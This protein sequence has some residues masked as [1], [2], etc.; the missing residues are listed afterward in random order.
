MSI[1]SNIIQ[2][3]QEQNKCWIRLA[4]FYDIELLRKWKNK[5]RKY[6][7]YK[8]IITKKQQ[9][10]WFKDYSDRIDDYIFI[11]MY[12]DLRVGCIGFRLID[13]VIDIY[14]VILGDIH[15][16][17]KGIMSQALNLMYGF[18]P[19]KD[20]TVKILTDNP[21]IKWYEKN[22]FFKIN[23]NKDY[24]LMGHK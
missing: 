16:K 5:N 13:D 15:F 9:L 8:Q 24:I 19:D 4:E 22:G 21:A 10:K 23:E 12:G 6:F 1:F 20:I 7:F 18:M 14:N 3:E 11:V 2:P 17:S